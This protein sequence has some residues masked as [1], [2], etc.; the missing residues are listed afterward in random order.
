[1]SGPLQ[2]V[3]GLLNVYAV[4]LFLASTVLAARQGRMTAS[5][6]TATARELL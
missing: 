5:A 1:M 2:R 3:G 6:T 4:L